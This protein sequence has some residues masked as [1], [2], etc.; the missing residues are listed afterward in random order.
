MYSEENLS[1]SVETLLNRI[2]IDNMELAKKLQDHAAA[3]SYSNIISNQVSKESSG[4][5]SNSDCK[6]SSG[7]NLKLQQIIE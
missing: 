5:D 2:L 6:F 4:G 3:P 7:I 1:R